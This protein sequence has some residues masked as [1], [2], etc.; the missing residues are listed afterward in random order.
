MLSERHL[1]I[2]QSSRK[3][4]SRFF[5][6]FTIE[7]S[8]NKNAYKL[9]LPEG[10]WIHSVF[11][12]SLLEPYNECKGEEIEQPSVLLIE[13]YEE[14]EIEVIL[15]DKESGNQCRFLVQWKNYLLKEAIWQAKTDLNNV[16]QLVNAYLQ[17]KKLWL[18]L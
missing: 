12:V 7:E 15:N 3:L 9:V 14:Y 2:T 16:K 1:C 5:E 10:Y 11:H 4:N 6:P 13:D 18:Q 8:M 17:K